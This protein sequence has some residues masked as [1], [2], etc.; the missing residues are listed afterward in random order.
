[1][2]EQQ[3]RAPLPDS[4]KAEAW[5][6]ADAAWLLGYIT[7]SNEFGPGSSDLTRATDVEGLKSWV[8]NYC[9]AHPLKT[10]AE[11]ARSLTHELSR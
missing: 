8:D 10:L 7:A 1:M 2:T 11:A 3:R 6:L 4:A 5:E 9:T